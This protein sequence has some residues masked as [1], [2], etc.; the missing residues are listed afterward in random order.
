[1]ARKAILVTDLGIDGAFAA[2]LALADPDID[3][4]AKATGISL[5]SVYKIKKTLGLVKKRKK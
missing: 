1:M 3:V 2:A 5:P 4:I